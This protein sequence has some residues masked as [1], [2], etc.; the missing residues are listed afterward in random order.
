MEI[1]RKD[2]VV[3]YV[4]KFGKIVNQELLDWVNANFN[5]EN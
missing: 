5:F 4:M 2:K 1:I 3:G